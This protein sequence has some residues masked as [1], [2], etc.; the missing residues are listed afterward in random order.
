VT[1]NAAPTAVA[2]LRADG[3][4]FDG[5]DAA[6]LRAVAASGSVSGAAGQLGR[7]RA[8][9]TT[10]L[11]ELAAAFG[12]LVERRRGGPE[13]GGS[14]LTDAGERLLA[15]FDRLRA[16]LAGTA[17][18]EESV[19]AGEVTAVVGET[20][21]VTTGAGTVSAVLAVPT[22]QSATSDESVSSDDSAS[23]DEQTGTDSTGPND[24]PSVA[25]GRRV[26]VTIRADAVT[27]QTPDATPNPDA[28]S[29]RNRFA[30]TVERVTRGDALVETAVAV[31]DETVRATVTANSADRLGLAPDREVVVSFKAT[32]TRAVPR[33]R[34]DE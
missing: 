24:E 27:V 32:A 7:S 5:N 25:V 4:R 15:R 28:T 19:L 13:G 10:R 12:P 14:R 29:A 1:E 22:A 8:R 21:R 3:V 17:A 18:A 16:T 34:V 6:L 11:E 30:G 33:P 2:G 31:G 26:D 20:V 9:A 23:G